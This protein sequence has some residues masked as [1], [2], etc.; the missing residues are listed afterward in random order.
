MPALSERLVLALVVL[1]DRL[2][3]KHD[4]VVV[5][6]GPDFDDQGREMVAALLRAGIGPV[7]VLAAGG[8]DPGLV[9]PLG[10]RVLSVRSFAGIRAFWRARVVVHSHGVFGSRA[11]SRRKVFVNV[12]HGMPIKRLEAGSDVGRYQTSW[13]IATAQ[14]HADHL[15]ETWNLTPDQVVITGLPRNDVLVRE[16]GAPRPGRLRA[17]AGDGPLV[18][19]LPTFR[20]NVATTAGAVV[21]GVDAGTVTQFAGATPEVV[22]ALMA[23]LGLHAIIKP[24]PLAPRPDRAEFPNLQVWADVDLADAG[25]TLYRLLAHADIVITDHSSVWIDY[26]LVQ[27]PMVFAVSDFA[28]YAETRGFYFS[29]VPDLLPGPMVID[30]AGLEAALAAA[31][32]GDDGWEDRRRDALERHHVHPDAHSADR[33][34]ALVGDVLAGRRRHRSGDGDP[35][36]SR[37]SAVAATAG[38]QGSP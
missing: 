30:L 35:A 10:C 28:E 4:E 31:V 38:G 11:T 21:D 5:R 29:S 36:V 6:T 1:G 26:L 15:A 23:R 34:A 24:H 14:V 16:A 22:D 25:L 17:F 9:G 12:W 7:T 33:V 37:S 13:T 3:P 8:A 2:A 19:W 27:R 32:A 18:A 20:T